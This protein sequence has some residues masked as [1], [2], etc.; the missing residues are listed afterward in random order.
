MKKAIYLFAATFMLLGSVQATNSVLIK[1]YCAAIAAQA[2]QNFLEDESL[3]IDE[4][5][6]LA[7]AV[8]DACDGL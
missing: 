7:I 4:C 1:R 6:E 3:S 2:Y 5:N 8:W